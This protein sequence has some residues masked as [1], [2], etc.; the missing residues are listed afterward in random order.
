VLG[1][2][3][4]IRKGVAE[5]IHGAMKN[6]IWNEG[7]QRLIKDL[8][9]IA[10]EGQE[11][12]GVVDGVHHRSRGNDPHDVLLERSYLLMQLAILVTDILMRLVEADAME[13]AGKEVGLAEERLVVGD[14]HTLALGGELGETRPGL[15]LDDVGGKG[16]AKTLARPLGDE[17][18]G[19]EEEGVDGGGVADE[20]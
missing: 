13:G 1:S 9:G 11:V 5:L 10:D 20:T 19:T 4:E 18:L 8:L 14:V 7:L 2:G 3:R 6:C 12:L 17:R 16:A 15:V